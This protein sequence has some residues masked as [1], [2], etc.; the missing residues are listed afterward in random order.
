MKKIAGVHILDWS[1]PNLRKYYRNRPPIRGTLNDRFIDAKKLGLT[2][3]EVPFDLV[4]LENNEHKILNKNVGDIITREDFKLLYGENAF[5][6]DGEY[7]LHTD[8]ELKKGHILY[9]NQP[10]WRSRYIESIIDFSDFVGKPPLAVEFHPSKLRRSRGHMIHLILEAFDKFRDAGFLPYIMIEN[11][12][13]MYISTAK[14]MIN[15][16]EKISENLASKE[17]SKFG[18][19]VDV[20]Q[21]YFQIR[22]DPFD[23]LKSL[24]KDSILGWHI[25]YKHNPPSDRDPIN[26]KN[27]SK[28]IDKNVFCLP[29]VFNTKNIIKT[30]NYIE[31]IIKNI[32]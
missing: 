28:L 23:D 17:L 13:D 14:D 5:E 27:I 3:I 31:E 18:F 30:I 25:H 32:I 16:Y 12:R 15:F 24:P 21:L 20:S 22:R 1:Y 2:R 11:R 8:P 10:Q 4:R 26:W 7:I 19:C 9:W 29:E 6:F